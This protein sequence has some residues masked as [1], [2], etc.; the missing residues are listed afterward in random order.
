MKPADA[1]NGF[2]LVEVIVAL[3]L[4][5]LIGMA[6]V[7][8]VDAVIGVQDRT[9]TRLDRIAEIRRANYII[10][11]D[12]DQIEPGAFAG[13]AGALQ[14]RRHGFLGVQAVGQVRYTVAAGTL[15]RRVDNGPAQRLLSGVSRARW[16]YHAA[17]R[18][19]I[20][21][22]AAPS[23]SP[24]RLPDGVAI[25]VRLNGDDKGPSGTFRRI[26]VLPQP[27]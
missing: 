11:L 10:G 8:L 1:E 14:F 21:A 4:F 5:A 9:R 3:G 25:D 22:W 16:R 7:A 24:T 27:S 2:T 15:Q 6:G 23:P 19:W 18:G 13:S 17:G 12:L 20:D 26:V